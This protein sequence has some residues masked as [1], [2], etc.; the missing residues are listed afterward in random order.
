MSARRI[1]A[2]L[3]LL[4]FPAS[5]L[6]GE[7][8]V[9]AVIKSKDIAPYNLAIKGFEERLK[10]QG[11]SPWLVPFDLEK[12]GTSPGALLE[13]VRRKKPDLLFTL[14]TKA[15]EAVAAS[16]HDLPV[17]YSIL[18]NPGPGITASRN[19]TGAMMDIPFKAQFEVLQSIL[20]GARTVGFLFNPA[21]TNAVIEEAD[22]AA[23]S[24]GLKVVALP[25]RAESD[26]PE[27]LRE[28]QGKADVLWMIADS[29]VYTPRSTEFILQESMK[30]EIPF[31]GLSARYVKAGA[32]F[33]ISWDY[34]DMGVQAAELAYRL[35]SGA[36]PAAVAPVTP[37]KLPLEINLRS[38]RALGIKI[39]RRILDQAEQVYE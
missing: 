16:I 25:V 35:L 22:R 11:L 20:P 37:R 4:S 13:E 9:V 3:A 29:T 1:L 8:M 14:G 24:M 10:Q 21:E 31:V 36:S 7:E 2:I 27:R 5:S 38:A 6:R 18:L 32:L 23:R 26:I 34:A 30:R 12:S 17:V 33:A 28:L 19:V 39:P 15:T